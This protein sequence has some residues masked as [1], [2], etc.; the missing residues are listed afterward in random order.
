MLIS[1][2][3]LAEKTKTE[4]VGNPELEISGVA[5]LES[6]TVSDISFLA[7]PRYA[8]QM[9]QSDAGCIV[10]SKTADSISG[11]NFLLSDDPSKTFQELIELFY[12][13][14]APYSGFTGIHPTATVHPTSVI[15]ENVTI[16]P[17]AVVDTKA[18]IGKGSFIG[19]NVYVGPH[20]TIGEGCHI[21]P[22][23]VIRESCQIG[24]RVIIQ[25]GAVI[26]SC[27]YGYTQDKNGRHTKLNQ[28]GNVILED[29]VEIGANTTIDR[30]RFKETRVGQG[31]KV[32]NLVQIAHG[33]IIGKHSLIIA[34]TGIAG[35]SQ[36][37]NHVILAGKV[38]VNGHIKICDGVVVG[39]CSGVSKSIT[40]PGRYAGVPVMPLAEHNKMQVYLRNIE[41]IVKDVH[42]LKKQVQ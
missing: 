39:A 15:G 36:I 2:K 27:G 6:A 29:D 11:K 40:T 22:N 28:V 14:R 20:V 42:A 18:K 38:A 23:V 10:I 31:T 3:E 7:N 5:D 41:K 9:L 12:A 25:P 33:V 1:L 37:G 8:A 24:N 19:S 34:Q 16:C 30:A 4:L 13:D 17:N 32:D 26:G 21:H 35:S